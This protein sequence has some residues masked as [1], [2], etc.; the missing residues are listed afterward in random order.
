[1]I[2][3]L[4]KYPCTKEEFRDGFFQRVVDIDT[5]FEHDERAY[6][7]ISLFR[8]ISSKMGDSSQT[9]RRSYSCNLFLHFFFIIK[10]FRTAKLVY[11]QSL[12]NALYSFLFIKYI[13]NTYVL[14]LHGVV[15]EELEYQGMRVKSA[16]FN[17]I[18]KFIFGKFDTCIAVTKRMAD[19]YKFKYPQSK[20]EY[21]VY[22]I[23]PANLTEYHSETDDHDN[24][25]NIIY[26]GNTQKWQNI[27]F[28]LALIK[29]NLFPNYKYTLL[30][31]ELEKM[32]DALV[33]HRLNKEESIELRSVSPAELKDYY[34]KAHYGFV[35]RDDIVV[36]NVA[37]PTKLVEYMF[38]GIIPIVLSDNVG[39]FKEFN[40][41]R[42]HWSK[43]D[44][45]LKARKSYSNV[46]IVKK[47]RQDNKFSLPKK[48]DLQ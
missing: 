35:L 9:L 44:K 41:D 27:D 46:E 14:D 29:K 48:D 6:L 18:E 38:Y 3:F 19:Y 45:H 1:M 8:N 23:F 17:S 11:V 21:I 20:C 2:L 36:N 4:S 32:K 33:R 7:S 30:T 28:M 31:G 16:V 40:Y 5:N 10:L 15:P 26:S 39:D 47:L 25:V 37:C 12:Y 22:T 34:K 43:M 24:G 13:K 42:I